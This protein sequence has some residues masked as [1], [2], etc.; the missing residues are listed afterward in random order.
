M[1]K[2]QSIGVIK[3]KNKKGLSGPEIHNDIG[4]YVRWKCTFICNNKKLGFWI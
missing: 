4:E 2:V 3:Y 1:E